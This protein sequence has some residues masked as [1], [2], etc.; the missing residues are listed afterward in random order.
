MQR[1]VDAVGDGTRHAGRPEQAKPGAGINRNA[2]LLEG[3]NIWK[4]RC[5]LAAG[6]CQ[7]PQLAG[8]VLFCKLGRGVKAD[9]DLATQ[10]VLHHG[11]AALERYM[12][13]RQL[14]VGGQHFTQKV[15]HGASGWRAIVGLARVGSKPV[16]QLA[17]VFGWGGRPGGQRQRKGDCVANGREVFAGVVLDALEHKRLNHHHRKGRQHQGVAVR[18]SVF[19]GLSRNAPTGA[20]PVFHEHRHA[21]A[22]FHFVGQHAGRDVSRATCWKPHQYFDRLALRPKWQHGQ[23]QAGGRQA[24]QD[25]F[26]VHGRA[27][28]VR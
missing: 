15:W 4:L 14:G 5:A 19:D 16:N 24:V 20:G 8:P 18:R 2:L 9:G 17:H 22:V 13:Q 27:L 11:C 7:Q 21:Q 28:L 25:V 12:G 3:G 10:Q 1:G 26:A 23:A 6:D